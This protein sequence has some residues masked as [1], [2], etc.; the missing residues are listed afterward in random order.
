MAD[1]GLNVDTIDDEIIPYMARAKKTKQF[2]E[3]FNRTQFEISSH[4]L[5]FANPKLA[6][7]S[8]K[9][10][11]TLYLDVVARV[12]QLCDIKKM[13]IE[14]KKLKRLM[15]LQRRKI[16]V[17]KGGALALF[18]AGKQDQYIEDEELGIIAKRD[19]MVY[20]N[21]AILA[22]TPSLNRLGIKKEDVMAMC[23][24][25]SAE[26]KIVLY[27]R[28]GDFSIQEYN[29]ELRY[30]M[31][32]KYNIAIEALDERYDV[33]AVNVINMILKMVPNFPDLTEKLDALLKRNER[34]VI[35]I[36]HIARRGVEDIEEE[37]LFVV[38]NEEDAKQGPYIK[39]KFDIDT[40]YI[41]YWNTVELYQIG[42]SDLTVEYDIMS[43]NPNLFV[44]ASII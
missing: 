26:D 42:A 6:I 25:S 30:I 20:F 37:K 17:L 15:A 7:G 3:I 40:Q 34:Q 35:D 16:E 29:P 41:P 23:V 22:L 18:T 12:Q 27:R 21:I 44:S 1:A 10:A 38:A 11:Q 31:V 14:Y 9:D 28:Y 2:V 39:G 24:Q 36:Q 32:K 19:V 8:M 43:D 5:P 13:A 4:L 33:S